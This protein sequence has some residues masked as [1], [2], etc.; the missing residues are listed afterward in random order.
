MKLLSYA[1]P[2]IVLSF[3]PGAH[4]ESFVSADLEIPAE[5]VG[6]AAGSCIRSPETVRMR[7]TQQAPG[8]RGTMVLMH[9]SS[10]Y[11]I[12][13]DAEGHHTYDVRVEIGQLRRRAGFHYAVWAATPELD[14]SVRLG[15]LGS[16]NHVTGRIAW[17]KFLVFVSEEADAG[18]ESW[19]GPILLTGLS[20]S[21]RMHT[22][23]GHGPFEDVS[24][25]DIGP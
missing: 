2:A 10:P 15:V 19:A 17:N 23:A 13:V 21:G 7:P 6:S 18:V 12:T 4:P 24:C 1:L 16:E 5:L 9:P 8:S 22:M 11:G 25:T 14:Q 3:G 20:P